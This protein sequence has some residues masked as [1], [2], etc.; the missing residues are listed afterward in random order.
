V[1]RVD[2]DFTEYGVEEPRVSAGDAARLHEHIAAGQRLGALDVQ[3]PSKHGAV[4]PRNVATHVV[5]PEARRIC[6][7][8]PGGGRM[9]GRRH[10][11]KLSL[12]PSASCRPPAPPGPAL[13][14]VNEHR[15]SFQVRHRV[16]VTQSCNND[17]HNNLQGGPKK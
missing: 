13:G 17:D 5:L 14:V 11:R 2:H 8:D 7:S 12:L 16:A 4:E 10:R 15:D 1:L 9:R 6:V 3:S